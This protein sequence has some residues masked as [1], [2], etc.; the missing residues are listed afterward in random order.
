ME[1]I[2]MY[3]SNMKNFLIEL[4]HDEMGCLTCSKFPITRNVQ[5]QTGHRARIF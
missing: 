1:V 5:A 2:E 3:F 4:S